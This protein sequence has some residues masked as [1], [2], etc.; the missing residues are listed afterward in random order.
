MGCPEDDHQ[1]SAA[2]AKPPVPENV[3]EAIRTLIRWAGDDPQRE[4]LIDTP[5]RVARA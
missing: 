3:Q 2:S 4:G 1:E 5:A